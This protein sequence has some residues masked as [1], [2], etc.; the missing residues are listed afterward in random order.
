MLIVFYVLNIFSSSGINICMEDFT[1][2][3][4]VMI[5]DF[6]I[7]NILSYCYGMHDDKLVCLSDFSSQNLVI[8][9]QYVLYYMYNIIICLYII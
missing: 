8:D 9:S 3:L 4:Y 6:L 1:L 2:S 5:C 7:N